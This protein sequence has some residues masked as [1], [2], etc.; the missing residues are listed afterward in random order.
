MLFIFLS[1][2]WILFRFLLSGYISFV[3][4]TDRKKEY[5]KN[6]TLSMYYYLTLKKGISNS[7]FW[8]LKRKCADISMEFWKR[9]TI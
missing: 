2:P 7:Y 3:E 6:M 8:C 9:K 4:V 5:N 1:V